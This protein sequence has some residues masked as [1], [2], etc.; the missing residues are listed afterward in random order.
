MSASSQTI[1]VCSISPRVSGYSSD[2]TNTSNPDQG[3][4]TAS[5]V[6]TEEN[7]LEC[8]RGVEKPCFD[9]PAKLMY[10]RKAPYDD[11]IRA[12]GIDTYNNFC[13]GRV[14]SMK[15]D[16]DKNDYGI[17]I[18]ALDYCLPFHLHVCLPAEERE[19]DKRICWCSCD[20]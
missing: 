2:Y 18:T 16:F 8:L 10:R 4:K 17:F 7:L 5:W 6:F 9:I 15:G 11:I 13:G 14:K 20:R 3:F 1:S 19:S 12:C